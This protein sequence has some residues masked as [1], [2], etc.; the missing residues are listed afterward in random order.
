MT[1]R[2][3]LEAQGWHVLELNWDDL[4][5]PRELVASIRMALN[6]HG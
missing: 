3:R 5:D 1:R 6:L 2:T 4:K